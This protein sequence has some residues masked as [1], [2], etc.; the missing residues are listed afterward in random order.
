MGERPRSLQE[1]IRARQA[2]VF[3]GRREQLRMFEDN[4]GLPVEDPRRRFLFSVFGDAGIGKSFLVR[5][6]A[7]V[8]GERG[9]LT[10]Y[11]DHGAADVPETMA[12]LVGELTR[13]GARCREF[14]DRFEAYQQRRRL[15]TA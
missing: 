14:D 13:G 9:W 15:L 10:G 6:L 3:V 11:V 4:L 8:A 5:Q 1:L 12:A 7:R 2:R